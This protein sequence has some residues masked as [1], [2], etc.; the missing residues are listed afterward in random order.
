MSIY[1]NR[2][3]SR[4][5]SQELRRTQTDN[6]QLDQRNKR[7]VYIT[8]ELK[9]MKIFLI[10]LHGLKLKQ[11]GLFNVVGLPLPFPM[12]P[13]VAHY[14]SLKTSSKSYVRVGLFPLNFE[15]LIPCFFHIKAISTLIVYARPKTVFWLK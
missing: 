1:I 6:I 10:G 8:Q 4:K 11:R 2:A 15:L 12:F 7:N 3:N 14:S 13:K 9:S 5:K